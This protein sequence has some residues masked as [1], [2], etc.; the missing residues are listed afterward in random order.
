MIVILVGIGCMVGA[1]A[2]AFGVVCWTIKEQ[3]KRK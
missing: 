2:I 1:A 3:G